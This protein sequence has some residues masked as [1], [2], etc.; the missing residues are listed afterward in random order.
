MLPIRLCLRIWLKLVQIIEICNGKIE[1]L[2][3]P[4]LI[5]RQSTCK[6]HYNGTKDSNASYSYSY[7]FTAQ[8]FQPSLMPKYSPPSFAPVFTTLHIQHELPISTPDS[9]EFSP[10]HG[11]YLHNDCEPLIEVSANVEAS[12]QS[13]LNVVGLNSSMK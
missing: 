2:R 13:L 3:E 12:W 7:S 1:D 11:V 6:K 10:V 4:H 8:E 5:Y 9:S